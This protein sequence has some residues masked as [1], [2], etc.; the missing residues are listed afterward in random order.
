M[1]GVSQRPF[2]ILLIEDNRADVYLL[3]RAL[4]EEAPCDITEL[5]DG[6]EAFVFT[7]HVNDS[8]PPFDL[9]V[10]DLN[11]PGRD[12]AEILLAIQSNPALVR[13]PVAV[14]SSSPCDII[15]KHAASAD[16]YLTKPCNLDEFMALAKALLDCARQGKR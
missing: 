5:A 4:Q 12:G 1:N 3:R 6:D 10:L 9:I 7:Q 14:L 15:K 2:K 16:Y 8:A 11:L 13:T